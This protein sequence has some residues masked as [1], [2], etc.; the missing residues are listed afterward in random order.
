M[1]VFPLMLMI[2]SFKKT[3]VY[4]AIFI[5]FLTAIFV[6]F[7][8]GALLLTIGYLLFTLNSHIIH[9][10]LRF[11]FT[12]GIIVTVFLMTLFF[13]IS[14][15]P[16]PIRTTLPLSS[17]IKDQIIKSTPL[18]EPRIYAW[19][20]A[21]Q[22]FTTHPI[23]GT[24]PGTYIFTS[25]RFQ[26]PLLSAATYA[27]SYPLQLL[28]EQGVLG[29]IPF[30]LLCI[31]V[32]KWLIHL[33]RLE[34]NKKTNLPSSL[35]I[36]L[37]DGV[38]LVCV[39][40]VID[41]NLDYLSIWVII[42]AVSGMLISK[43]NPKK[44]S[45]YP[46]LI[47]LSI[48]LFLYSASS[49]LGNKLWN[50]QDTNTKGFYFTSFNVNRAQQHIQNIRFYNRPIP[51][52]DLKLIQLFHRDS[53]P[54][55]FA[56]AELKETSFDEPIVTS[57]YKQAIAGEP[58]NGFYVAKY[59]QYLLQKNNKQEVSQVYEQLVKNAYA[60]QQKQYPSDISLQDPV[61]I[62]SYTPEF[63]KLLE[64]G[65]L[66]HEIVAKSLYFLGLSQLETNTEA[67]NKL[68]LMAETISPGWSLFYI[69]RASYALYV[70]KNEAKAKEILL[71]CEKIYSPS[72][73]CTEVL[74]TF[75]NLPLPGAYKDAIRAIPRY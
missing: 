45:C 54:I 1:F 9:K 71:A 69:E 27:H 16:E 75:P 43:M 34:Q 15:L 17:S 72:K 8:R 48:P 58:F 6:S 5:L 18:N 3:W 4:T 36:G 50:V 37:I 13:V 59:M 65:A 44:N 39:H 62:D 22:G 52:F 14:M 66:L 41:Y 38:L 61:F 40:S 53:P 31:V 42:W 21:I 57:L 73:A 32:G 2:L 46:L 68:W 30:V 10:K 19:R 23:I 24:G 67:T 47:V 55:Q 26:V 29:M 28:S 56:L 35:T 20:Q 7:S 12:T 51:P 70:E 49:I 60:L 63:A 25:K 64:K 33:R 74:S 11:L